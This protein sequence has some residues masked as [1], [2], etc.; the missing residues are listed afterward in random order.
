MAIKYN[1]TLDY[2]ALSLEAA[3]S[4][5]TKLAAKHLISASVQKDAGAAIDIIEASNAHAIKQDKV[6]ASAVTRL[7]AALEDEVPEDEPEGEGEI[8]IPEGDDVGEPEGEVEAAEEPLDEEELNNEFE[9]VLSS[10]RAG[11]KKPVKAASA[12]A[13]PAATPKAAPPKAA[14]TRR[15]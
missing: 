2:L 11:A 14:A 9:K 13:K 10:M 4:G 3:R 5:D 12:P 1:R 6:L 8:E 7:A 15:A